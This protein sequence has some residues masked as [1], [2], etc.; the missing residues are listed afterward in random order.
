[1]SALYARYD[2]VMQVNNLIMR[3]LISRRMLDLFSFAIWVFIS[4]FFVVF[5]ASWIA[6]LALIVCETVMLREVNKLRILQP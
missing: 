3:D 1:M 2:M 5:A 6:L 4:L